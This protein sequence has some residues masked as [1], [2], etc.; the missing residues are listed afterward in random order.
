MDASEDRKA[1]LARVVG[2][3]ILNCGLLARP[4]GYQASPG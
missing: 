1:N 2:A 3:T 4:D